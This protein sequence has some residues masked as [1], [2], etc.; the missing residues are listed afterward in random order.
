M[1]SSMISSHDLNTMC[2][3][4]IRSWVKHS[5]AIW[6]IYSRDRWNG[7]ELTSCVCEIKLHRSCLFSLMCSLIL[8]Y[9]WSCSLSLKEANR[10]ENVKCYS[11]LQWQKGLVRQRG[12]NLWGYMRCSHY[13][14]N[15]FLSFILI[16]EVT[17]VM[18]RA[19][20]WITDSWCRVRSSQ[21]II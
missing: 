14:P 12:S 15:G 11:E 16:T 17:R 9:P 4:S 10:R 8:R 3:N 2:S 20:G 21:D 13:T 6:F 18:E 19:Y 1:C 5:L 7:I